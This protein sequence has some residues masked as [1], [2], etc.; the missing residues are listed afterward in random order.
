MIVHELTAADCA[1]V[2]S[3]A[4]VGRL[5]CCRMNQP[6]VV[7]VSIAYDPRQVCLFSF[8]MIGKK[9]EWMRANPSVCV[10]VE[11]L[12]DR[13]NWT[14][15]V[16]FGRYDEID[17]APEQRDLRHRALHLFSDRSQ[18]WLPGAARVKGVEHDS[19]VVFRINI[20]HMSG[21]RT[22]RSEDP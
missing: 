16:V 6:Y 22:A 21:R 19:V 14:T 4:T 13:F 12:D 3:R 18:W 5:A 17:D 2:L 9:V 8:S 10:E 11:D 1:G 20:D 15:V 7:P